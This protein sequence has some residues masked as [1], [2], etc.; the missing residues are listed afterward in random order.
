M[1]G[2]GGREDARV[3][4]PLIRSDDD[5]GGLRGGGTPVGRGGVGPYL[6]RMRP[7]R[8][9][10]GVHLGAPRGF[11]EGGG[12]LTVESNVH[13]LQFRAAGGD[14]GVDLHAIALAGGEGLIPIGG[15]KSGPLE[16][17]QVALRGADLK[18]DFHARKVNS[19]LGAVRHRSRQSGALPA[20]RCFANAWPK[21]SLSVSRMQRP[22]R[23][24]LISSKVRHGWAD[25]S[26]RAASPAHTVRSTAPAVKPPAGSTDL[27]TSST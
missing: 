16:T 17:S 5:Q 15:R 3:S 12:F 18:D 27:G 22:C 10:L 9:V 1:V 13:F 11:R 26:V 24:F 7:D 23:G 19:G 8:E 20:R 21:A 2:V 14:Q 25:R 4:G 6:E